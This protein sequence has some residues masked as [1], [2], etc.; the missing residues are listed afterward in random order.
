MEVEASWRGSKGLKVFISLILVM[1]LLILSLIRSASFLEVKDPLEKA[2]AILVLSGDRLFGRTIEAVNLY[3]KGYAK[4]LIFIGC[5]RAVGLY[6]QD[7]PFVLKRK[8]VAMGVPPSSILIASK[9]LDTYGE[10][11]LAREIIAQNHFKKVILITSPFHQ[12][13]AYLLA[14]KQFRTLRVEIL[15]YPAGDPFWRLEGW[16]KRAEMRKLIFREY[17]KII[18]SWFLGW[19]GPLPSL[20]PPLVSCEDYI[21]PGI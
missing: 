20:L 13:R 5:A 2:D 12:R 6:N 1:P 8:A 21:N 4:H 11:I 14:R 15:N 7:N 19:I 10:I 18:G 16:W 17:K 9:S 3:K